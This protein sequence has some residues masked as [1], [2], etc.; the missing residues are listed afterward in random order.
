MSEHEAAGSLYTPRLHPQ[1]LDEMIPGPSTA[2]TSKSRCHHSASGKPSARQIHPARADP[3]SPVKNWPGRWA[4]TRPAYLRS[5][6]DGA[7]HVPVA[8][9]R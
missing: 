8:T 4:I 2:A 6:P 7:A 5:P 1:S 9:A 3:P